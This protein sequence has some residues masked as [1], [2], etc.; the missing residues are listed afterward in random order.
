MSQATADIVVNTGDSIPF[1]FTPQANG[2]TSLVAA[3]LTV[4]ASESLQDLLSLQ[5]AL[6]LL[7]HQA[8]PWPTQSFNWFCY[9][10]PTQK[11]AV[12]LTE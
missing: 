9:L 5:I 3:S 11:L 1:T 10:P 8:Y 4:V 7:H 2:L 6:L 12:C